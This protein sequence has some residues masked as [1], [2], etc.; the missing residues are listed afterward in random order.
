MK[1]QAIKGLLAKVREDYDDPVNR[2]ATFGPK[3]SPQL[4]LVPEASCHM[5]VA[6]VVKDHISACGTR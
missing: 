3:L 2:D 5:G 1:I 4:E 6:A